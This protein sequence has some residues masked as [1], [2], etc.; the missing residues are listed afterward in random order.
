[1]LFHV[2]SL[3]QSLVWR[4]VTMNHNRN[5]FAAFEWFL[6]V[7]GVS[8]I[9][10]E[11]PWSKCG[12][13]GCSAGVTLVKRPFPTGPLRRRWSGIGRIRGWWDPEALTNQA[14][15][16]CLFRSFPIDRSGHVLFISWKMWLGWHH[17]ELN[18]IYFF[19]WKK[20]D[21]PK[22]PNWNHVFQLLVMMYLFGTNFR[23]DMWDAMCA[24]HGYTPM[25]FFSISSCR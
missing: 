6:M 23:T 25:I 7:V 10:P 16:V 21:A 9:V 5:A 17:N 22:S 4:P 11:I 8:P 14:E 2:N 3:L 19:I 24:V 20:F 12:D 1:M 15:G 18:D 13:L